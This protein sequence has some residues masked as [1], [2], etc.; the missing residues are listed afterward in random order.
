[1]EG[2]YKNKYL[3]Y[4][5]KYL[6][7]GECQNCAKVGF[8]Q[9]HG[10]CWHDSF[11]TIM[12]FSDD[13][14]EGIQKIFSPDFDAAMRIRKVISRPDVYPKYFLPPNISDTGPEFDKFCGF[15][16]TYLTNLNKL[17]QNELKPLDKRID[18]EKL[19]LSCIAQSFNVNNINRIQEKKYDRYDHG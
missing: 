17:Y 15:A 9:H 5:Q 1:M 13:F 6:Q 7:G 16:N 4:K 12:L 14:S 10:E 8:E 18:A 11:S 2:F 3:K 19:S